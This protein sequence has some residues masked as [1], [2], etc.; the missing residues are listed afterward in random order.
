MLKKFKLERISQF[1]KSEFNKQ[2]D[3]YVNKKRINRAVSLLVM[4]RAYLFSN[5]LDLHFSVAFRLRC[6]LHK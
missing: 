2:T 6:K 3:V 1:K 4:D 5:L